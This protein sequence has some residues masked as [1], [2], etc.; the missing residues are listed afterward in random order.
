MRNQ[1][2]ISIPHSNSAFRISEGVPRG[3][4]GTVGKVTLFE[5]KKMD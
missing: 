2:R 3:T 5:S 4:T 1:N